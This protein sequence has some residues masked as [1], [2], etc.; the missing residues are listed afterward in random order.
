MP[1]ICEFTTFI[2]PVSICM[3]AIIGRDSIWFKCFNGVNVLTAELLE[4]FHIGSNQFTS[5]MLVDL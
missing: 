3:G 2:S 4:L 5:T 1:P